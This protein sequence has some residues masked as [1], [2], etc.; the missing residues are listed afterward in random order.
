MLLFYRIWLRRRDTF[1]RVLRVSL[2]AALNI[3]DLTKRTER[4]L[5][6]TIRPQEEFEDILCKMAS[7]QLDVDRHASLVD[8]ES[9]FIQSIER[10][11]ADLVN[12]GRNS[13]SDSIRSLSFGSWTIAKLFI[14]LI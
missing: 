12:I 8:R 4:T 2:D 14:A 6:A 3:A 10:A 13:I 5:I 1:R 11:A 7:E 9:G